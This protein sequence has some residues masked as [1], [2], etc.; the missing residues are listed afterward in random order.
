MAVRYRIEHVTRYTYSSR[1]ATSQHLAYLTPRALARQHLLE[2]S[3][4]I[5]PEPSESLEREDYFGNRVRQFTVL[6]PHR[7]C[8]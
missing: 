6:A 2:H 7:S 4:T 5:D 8:R 3:L 1:V